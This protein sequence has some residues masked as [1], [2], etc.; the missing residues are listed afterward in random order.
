M[1][2]KAASVVLDALWEDH[3]FRA[4]FHDHDYTLADLGPLIHV[5]FVPAYLDVKA[6]LSSGE[7][8]LLEAQ[9]TEDLLAPLYDRP[10]FRE[11][12]ES[13][14]QATRHEFLREQSEMQLARLL[15]MVYDAQLAVAFQE[16][17]LNYLGA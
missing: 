17:F 6:L 7:L 9:V 10:T 1:Y 14:D 11:A 13:W 16:A 15:V 2:D 8:A 4:F 3:D 12:W 5:V